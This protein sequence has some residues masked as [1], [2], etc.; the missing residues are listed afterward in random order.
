MSKTKLKYFSSETLEQME[1]CV[2]SNLERYKHDGFEDMKDNRGWGAELSIESD[3]TPL[4]DLDPSGSPAAEIRNSLL[5]WSVLYE[6]TPAIAI[7]NRFWSRLAHVN[8]FEFTRSRWPVDSKQDSGKV[9][10]YIKRHFFARTLTNCRDDHAVSRLWWNAK[11]AKILRPNDQ[12]RALELILKTADIRSNFVERSWTVSRPVVARAILKVME[13]EEWATKAE[14]NF[15][16]LM[17][18]INHRG[19]GIVFELLSEDE[20]YSFMLDCHKAAQDGN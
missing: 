5:V 14:A 4:S 2:L 1:K 8:C 18:S 9:V 7:E 16:S 11:I 12:R 3:L 19:G 20:V 6:L 15:R 17:R 10:E 13:E